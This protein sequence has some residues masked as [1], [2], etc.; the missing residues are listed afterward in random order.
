M[1]SAAFLYLS[2]ED[3]AECGGSDMA[4]VLAKV[5]RVLSLHHSGDV[6]L[7]DKI[8][9]RWGDADS[10][11]DIG[12]INGMPAYV[13]AEVDMAGIK[14]I[15]SKP[16]NPK[17]YGLPR[18]SG[19]II[20]NDSE[21]G[22]PVAVM[23]GTLISAMRTGAVTGV[24]AKYLANKATEVVA[25]YGAG[26]QNRTQLSALVHALPN[27]S[28]VRVHDP[29]RARAERFVAM[30][31]K[32][33]PQLAFKQVEHAQAAA[34][35][36]QCLITA[37]TTVKPFIKKAWIQPG[38]FVANIGNYEFEFSAVKQA[39]KIVGDNFAAII[40]RNVQTIALMIHQHQLE[41]NQLYGELGEIING[42]KKGREHDE[43]IIYFSAVGMGAEDVIVAQE[44]YES[45]RSMGKGI[46]LHLWD[47][48]V[49]V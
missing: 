43:E 1:K 25:L 47:K 17:K 35:G 31:S 36:A 30:E 29:S 26:V 2:L 33:Y 5:E 46:A 34:D 10:E 22:L 44:I 39:D 38:M 21:T 6:I 3:V 13:G 49:W 7:P 27:L 19:L 20:L 8:N 18:A 32:T 15:A 41:R 37:T 11:M 40:H 23:D 24:A 48:P 9:L 28:E 42:V 4:S 16:N 45:A 12:R 14:W